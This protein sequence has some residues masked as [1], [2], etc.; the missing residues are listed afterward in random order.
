MHV[1]NR[2]SQ[3]PRVEV[4]CKGIMAINVHF[5]AGDGRVKADGRSSDK[6]AKRISLI[7][8]PQFLN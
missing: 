2:K 7:T 4:G 1:A 5:E 8:V 3:Y 6:A